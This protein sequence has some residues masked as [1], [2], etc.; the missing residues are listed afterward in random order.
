MT[1]LLLNDYAVKDCIISNLILGTGSYAEFYRCQITGGT[2]AASSLPL[3]VY[4]IITGG[5]F[6]YYNTGALRFPLLLWSCVYGNVTLNGGMFFESDVYGSAATLNDAEY[7]FYLSYV[8][9]SITLTSSHDL[10]LFNCYSPLN[11]IVGNGGHLVT[12]KTHN[13]GTITVNGGEWTK[14]DS[15]N[16]DLGDL[17]GGTTGQYYHLTQSAY[18]NLTSGNIAANITGTAA[19]LSGTPNVSLNNLTVA[20]VAS[21]TGAAITA[22]SGTGITVNSA[23][24]VNRQVYKVTTT[25]GTYSDTDTAKGVVIATLPAKTKLLAVYADTTETYTGTSITGANLVVGVS[26]EN[27]AE[28]LAQHEHFTSSLT[29]GLADADMGIAMTRAAS[30]QGGYFPS[31]T[32]STDVYATINTTGANTDQL[33][34]GSTTFYLVTERF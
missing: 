26:A 27:S 28:I 29:K 21:L 6:S 13:S 4:S 25:Y 8:D 12:A 23:G 7:H 22:G 30:I 3:F 9:G 5:T 32:G 18:N 17:Q 10:V 15:H 14:V 24:N 31:W 19:G 1:G 20:G 2:L 11:I 33:A 34:T 16:N